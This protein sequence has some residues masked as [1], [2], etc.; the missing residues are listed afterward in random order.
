LHCQ[1]TFPYKNARSQIVEIDRNLIT[2]LL[3]LTRN[4]LVPTILVIKEANLPLSLADD[5]ISK[6]QTEGLIHLEGSTVKTTSS[7]RA[8]L[9][10]LAIEQGA[11]PWSVAVLLNWEEF[12]H[13]S[14]IAFVKEGY[15]A[16]K[17][18]RFKQNG[19]KWEIDVV[20]Y[21]RP[22]VVCADCKHWRV[23]LCRSVLK[24]M[25][26]EQI[27]RASALLNARDVMSE[28]LGVGKEMSTIVPIVLSLMPSS[29]Q[30]FG[31]VPIVPVLKLHDFLDKLPMHV[32]SLFHFSA[33]AFKVSREKNHNLAEFM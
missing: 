1:L 23:G 31:G 8:H 30:Y 19:R 22:L 20:G 26:L 4:E 7:Q 28:K 5:L 2:S 10:I 27:A 14:F 17:N 33:E 13:I 24:K 29:V 21:R 3:K 16:V 11:D 32:S 25:T 12:E 15:A 6:L 9:A 18:L